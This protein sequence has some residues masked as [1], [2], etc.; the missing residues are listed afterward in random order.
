MVSPLLRLAVWDTLCDLEADMRYC[1]A[2]SAKKRRFHRFLRL[3]LLT[4]VVVE[5]ALLY[6]ATQLLWLLVLGVAVGVGLALLTIWD[7]M[8]DY[9]SEAA[10]LKIIA[11]RCGSL[12]R[13]TEVLWRKI[14]TG[15]DDATKVE[16]T[17]KEV[18]DQWSIVM[19]W[20]QSEVD[21]SLKRR[22]EEQANKEVSNRFVDRLPS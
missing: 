8:S 19:Q 1:A 14:E 4:G 10:T 17:L 5:A 16:E 20:S 21:L 12:T 9:A 2:L 18:Q 13:E 11:G 15:F 6:G 22:T 7:A 3:G